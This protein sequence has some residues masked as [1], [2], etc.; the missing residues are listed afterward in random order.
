[1]RPR[2]V[3]RRFAATRFLGSRV[4]IPPENRIFSEFFGV[5]FRQRSLRP[6]DLSSRGVLPAV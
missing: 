5:F 4:Q 1:M 3:R 2:G 6:S